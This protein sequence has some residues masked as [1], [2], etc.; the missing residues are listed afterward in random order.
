[1]TGLSGR[2]R[3]PLLCLWALMLVCVVIGSLLPAASPVI[4]EIG[5][6]HVNDKVM[7]FAA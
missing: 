4:V 2:F 7:H 6:L 3:T 1:M 5:S